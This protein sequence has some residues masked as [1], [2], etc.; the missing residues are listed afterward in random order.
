MGVPE[1]QIVERWNGRE[2]ALKMI[3]DDVRKYAFSGYLRVGLAEKG[4][5]SEGVLVFDSGE[6]LACAYFYGPASTGRERLY[7][8]PKAAEFIWQDSVLPDSVITLHSK[9]PPKDV[10]AIL[11]DAAIN[12]VEMM[13]PPWLPLPPRRIEEAE[14]DDLEAE[15]RRR[16]LEWSREGY[17]LRPLV[18]LAERDPRRAE[19]AI[20]Y[21]GSNIQKL[22]E[23]KEALQFLKTEGYEREAVSLLRKMV[24]PE[25]A[26][27]AQAEL[28][29]LRKRIERSDSANSAERQIQQ[30]MERKKLDE[31]ID[32]V[33]DLIL[34][35]H[36][37]SSQ[38]VP[39]RTRC[40]SCGGPLD[41]SGNCLRCLGG[42]A[43]GAQY[44]RPLNPR[45]TFETF[46]AGPNS[47]FAEAAAKAVVTS[48]GKVYNP[49]F[50]YSK[51][52]LG[53]THLLQAIGNH[54]LMKEEAAV[55][56]SSAEAIEEELV[57]S[58]AAKKLDEFRKAYRSAGMLLID[59]VQFLAGKERIQEELFQAFT[60]LI[61]RGR[62]I[63]L[64]SD[65]LP[66]AIPSLGE[67]L[68]TRFES[69]LIVDIQPPDLQ[70]RLAILERK[71]R[72]EKLAIPKDVLGFVAEVCRDNVRQLEGGLN[73]VVAFASLMRSDITVDLAKEILSQEVR[74]AKSSRMKVELQ[75]GQ[76]YLVE[77]EKPDV[78]HRLFVSKLREGY[79]G[80]A[81]TR[82]HPRSLREKLAGA[83]AVVFW[84][85]DHESKTERTVSPSLERIMLL[86][87]EFVHPQRKCIVLLDDIQYLI[88]NTTFEGI[89]R[90]IRTVVDEVSE[91]PAIFLISVSQESLR[92]QDRSILEREMEVIRQEQT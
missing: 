43:G 24:D 40:P 7:R 69:G 32:G 45:Y 16:V 52:G 46:V 84:L 26:S 42:K 79:K 44:G 50:I 19:K 17:D 73:R 49:L 92:T 48:P 25:R 82:G 20:A 28:E 59:D 77:E 76:S 56:Y 31:R 36:K 80:L 62:Q 9:V 75:D 15:S 66:Q 65:R 60:A 47:S 83:E 5:R 64:A 81:I 38:G 86:I 85:T 68:A 21:Y 72:E 91:R 57:A 35:Y 23:M 37:M 71:A 29:T 34:Q 30:D 53:K 8:G 74:E 14:V 90:F 6:P 89:I 39:K 61:E 88:S 13:P 27:D 70:T 78:S 67:R 63:A 1:G 2:D 87:E 41:E 10:A 55:M 18:L 11:G 22:R 51:S 3:L 54:I 58:L 4:S 33:Y 12:R